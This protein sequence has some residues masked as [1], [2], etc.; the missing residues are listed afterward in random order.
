[1]GQIDTNSCQD[2]DA[3]HGFSYL[4]SLVLVFVI[5]GIQVI[6]YL[7]TSNNTQTAHPY[8]VTGKILRLNIGLVRTSRPKSVQ[9]IRSQICL[10]YFAIYR[11]PEPSSQPISKLL[12]HPVIYGTS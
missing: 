3:H 12:I 1:M 5:Y 11:F 9:K 6:I 10:F 8:S 2:I 7:L 4:S